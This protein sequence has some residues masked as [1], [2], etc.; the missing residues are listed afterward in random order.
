MRLDRVYIDGFKNLRDVSVEFDETR[1][2]SVII[3]ENGSGKSNLIE[4]ITDVFRFVDINRGRPRYTY[5]IEYRIKNHSVRIS[6]R[7]S[8]QVIEVDGAAISRAA[9]ERDKSD[10]FPDLVFGYYSGGSRRLERLFDPHQR[11][12]YDTIKR[13]SDAE[14]CEQALLERRL[15]YC[16]P[17]HGVLALLS[18]FAFPDPGVLA[19]LREKLGITGF[20]SA[21]ATFRAPSWFRESQRK[22]V[23]ASSE[24][25]GALG[26]AGECAYD[27][28]NA[29]FFPISL[30]DRPVDDYR[31][32]TSNEAQYACFLKDRDALSKVSARYGD[33]DSFQADQT[34]FSAL[35][36]IDIS[37]LIRD[38]NIWVTRADDDSGDVS[39]SDLSDGERQLLMV[40]GLVR[41]SRGK[42][43]LFLLDEPDTH[44]NPSWQNSYLELIREWTGVAAEP[45]KCQIV[46]CTHN[47]LTIASLVHEE[48]R[49]MGLD[50]DNGISVSTPN[51][52]PRGLGF[53]GVLT[54]IF[55][56]PSTLDQPTQSLIDR[57]NEL[58]RKPQLSLE[59]TEAL[60][61]LNGELNSLGFQ[62][63]ERDEVYKRYLQMID[64]IELADAEP[65]SAQE[66]QTRD[67]ATRELLK[68]LLTQ[69]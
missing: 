24:F 6:N 41:I 4:A 69:K 7:G 27:I 36:A 48:V 9:F 50:R 44:L 34:F 2:T 62:Y 37:D 16:R 21:L 18:F 42:E 12:Y 26:P 54:D 45:D 19:L 10:I 11:R 15:F 1:L 17:I 47:P 5:D 51:V 31:E 29:A 56:M 55:G 68:E 40:L 59:E 13:N 3:G 66:I 22:K 63:P 58:S 28:K 67:E 33:S 30:T 60:E 65:L 23:E 52:D 32:R 35:E 57:R 25:W 43:A 8:E 39:Y 49:V 64:E 38:I 14:E 20:H 61:K 53:A 46:M